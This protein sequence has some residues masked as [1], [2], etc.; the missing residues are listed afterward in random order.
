MIARRKEQARKRPEI[1]QRLGV[2][3][4]TWERVMEVVEAGPWRPGD[5]R[6]VLIQVRHPSAESDT[7]HR[8]S[9]VVIRRFAE[10]LAAVWEHGER[11]AAYEVTLD[12]DDSATA[13]DAIEWPRVLN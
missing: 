12:E 7:G 4:K 13:G 11:V 9:A 8:A 2:D 1:R 6:S 3:R 5:R 10:M